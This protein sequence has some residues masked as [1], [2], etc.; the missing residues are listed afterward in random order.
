MNENTTGIENRERLRQRAIHYINTDPPEE[1]LAGQT[2]GRI[3]GYGTFGIV[4]EILDREGN[5]T[6]EVVKIIDFW[7]YL[8]IYRLV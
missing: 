1:W 2:I 4:C 5:E 6:D 8:M 3:L 7:E